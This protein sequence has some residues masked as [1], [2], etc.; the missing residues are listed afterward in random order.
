MAITTARK[1]R[2]QNRITSLETYRDSLYELQTNFDSVDSY[3]FDSGEGSQQT[4]FRSLTEVN[5]AIRRT[6]SSIERLY[7]ILAGHGIV[8]VNLRRN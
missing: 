8:N 4:K 6:Q 2:I 7:R 3:R 1:T 5:M